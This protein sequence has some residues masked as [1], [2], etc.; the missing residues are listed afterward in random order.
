MH[1]RLPISSPARPGPENDLPNS[2]F[3]RMVSSTRDGQ[4]TSSV[5]SELGTLSRTEMME[6]LQRSRGLECRPIFFLSNSVFQSVCISWG[7]EKQ[8][9]INRLLML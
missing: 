8:Q 5:P 9:F 2:L 4:E 7:T 3:Q 6:S 1:R